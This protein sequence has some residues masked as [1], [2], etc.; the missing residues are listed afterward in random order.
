MN[1]KVQVIAYFAQR[2]MVCLNHKIL[3]GETLDDY[4]LINGGGS[5]GL[6][7]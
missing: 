2:R 7:T 5:G 3:F 6:P 4:A 1:T